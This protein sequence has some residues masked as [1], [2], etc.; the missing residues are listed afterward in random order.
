MYLQ[1]YQFKLVEKN[2]CT[3]E[4]S[5]HWTFKYVV[6]VNNCTFPNFNLELQSDVNN[7]K[8]KCLRLS[9]CNFIVIPFVIF[10]LICN[11]MQLQCI[12]IS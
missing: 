3:L 9:F 11:K 8:L 1:M 7:K 6:F 12:I 4:I 2:D 5:E 10:D